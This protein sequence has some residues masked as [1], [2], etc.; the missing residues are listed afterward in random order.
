MAELRFLE[1]PPLAVK[2]SRGLWAGCGAAMGRLARAR[3]STYMWALN[4]YDP[5]HKVDEMG[6][7]LWD[8]YWIVIRNLI[9]IYTIVL[10]ISVVMSWLISFGVINVRNQVVA[11]IYRIVYQV[12]EPALAPIRNILPSFGGLDFSPIVLIL[13]LMFVDRMLFRLLLPYAGI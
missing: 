3:R 12:T 7:I 11:T 2:K 1:V 5:Q 9:Q 10:I 6:G 13:G 4:W 8:F